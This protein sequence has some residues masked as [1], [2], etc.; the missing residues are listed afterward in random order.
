MWEITSGKDLKLSHDGVPMEGTERCAPE[1]R[2][3]R[4]RSQISYSSC[5]R[6]GLSARG[7]R[8]RF[9]ERQQRE[10]GTEEHKGSAKRL[11]VRNPAT[12]RGRMNF[13]RVFR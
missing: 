9:H 8:T 11:D 6:H 3:T 10:N 12:G 13:G 4:Y 7:D 1:P 5:L 2:Q